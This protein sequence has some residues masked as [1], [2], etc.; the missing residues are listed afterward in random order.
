MNKGDT[1]Y[2]E[3]LNRQLEMYNHRQQQAHNFLRLIVAVTI[4]LGV[5]LLL[6]LV[7]LREVILSAHR[8]ALETVGG[9][10]IPSDLISYSTALIALEGGTLLL[11]SINMYS[12]SIHSLR[13]V[14]QHDPPEP[15]LGG[16]PNTSPSRRFSKYNISYNLNSKVHS[17]AKILNNQQESLHKAYE[18]ARLGTIIFL[19]GLAILLWAIFL[20]G[21]LSTPIIFISAI[22]IFWIVGYFMGRIVMFSVHFIANLVSRRGVDGKDAIDGLGVPS[23]E[24]WGY[25]ISDIVIVTSFSF[26]TPYIVISAYWSYVLITSENSPINSPGVPNIPLDAFFWIFTI[27]ALLGIFHAIL[28]YINENESLIEDH[29]EPLTTDS[30][31][32]KVLLGKIK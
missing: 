29:L 9:G 31:L 7:Q 14:L 6:R 2:Q 23:V 26:M 21:I 25:Q 17:N 10:Y 32:L 19:I 12:K 4:I 24:F 16:D 15:F 22:A 28:K 5:P 3:E 8:L 27:V 20:V 1:N 30:N 11:F 18:R 13:L